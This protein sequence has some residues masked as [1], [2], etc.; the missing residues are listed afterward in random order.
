[1]DQA[2]QGDNGAKSFTLRASALLL[3]VT[4]PFLFAHFRPGRSAT[5]LEESV[6]RVERRD[7]SQS[8]RLNG[9]TQASR[10][11]VVLA[12]KLE[13]AQVG[14]M[15]ITK[16]A[17]AGTHIKKGD[18]LVEFDPQ[19]QTKDYLEKKGAYESLVGQVA[20]KRAEEAIAS[21]KDDT[22]MKQ[23]EDE[24]KRAQLELQKNEIVS[25]IDA[26]KNQEALDEAQA[27]LKQLKETYQLKRAAAAATIRI[28]EIQRDR[29]LEAMRYAQGN[30]AKMV[31]HSPMPGVVVYNTIWLGGRMGTVQQGDQVRPGVPFL[32]V[33]DPSQMEVR[34]QLNQVDL[35]KVHAGQH[36]EMHLDA[37][38]GMT[39]PAVLEEI[40][41]LGHTGQFTEAVRT[42][43]ASFSVQGTDP[44][45]LP[46]L[47]AALDLDLGTQ[48]KVLV[49]PWQSI[50]MEAGHS[51]VWLKTRVG[52]EKRSVETRSRNDLEAV[53]NSGLSEGD[54]IRQVA[55]EEQPGADRQ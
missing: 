26:E 46:D 10:S 47:S 27:T 15:V 52:F 53:V 39:L 35:L 55:V 43:T 34:V 41:P 9:T 42:F 4:T 1:M 32:Q 8:L 54:T 40:S 31:V 36:A 30:A 44:R 16:L 17:P 21:S 37:Y 28:Q 5:N 29:A 14:S 48:K 6:I 23:A 11:F 3:L 24:L 2:S 18:F 12:P 50:G 45:L 19:A 38:P 13:G 25:R 49:V 22:A 51:F 7:F 33:V 20:Q